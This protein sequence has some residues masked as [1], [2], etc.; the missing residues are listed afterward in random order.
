[1]EEFFL[2]TCFLLCLPL[3]Y[4]ALQWIIATVIFI[5]LL[6]IVLC[7]AWVVIFWTG[8][9]IVFIVRGLIKCWRKCRRRI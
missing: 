9:L 6:L 1:M 2:L 7:A 4:K 3:L 5:V 8:A